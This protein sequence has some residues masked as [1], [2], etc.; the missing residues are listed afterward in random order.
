[1]TVTIDIG[2][3]TE[4]MTPG[5]PLSAPKRPCTAMSDSG[6]IRWMAKLPLGMELH[7]LLVIMHG[8]ADLGIHVDVAQAVEDL[9]DLAMALAPVPEERKAQP[10][11]ERRR[12]GDRGDVALARRQR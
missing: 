1:M 11:A 3:R 7:V 9:D 8:I 10:V 2:W 6:E 5:T 4:S 12:I